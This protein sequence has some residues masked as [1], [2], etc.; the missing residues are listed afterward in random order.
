M[1]ATHFK[2]ALSTRRECLDI[3]WD[4]LEE[5]WKGAEE[6][7]MANVVM[8]R[9][10]AIKL[11]E[12]RSHMTRKIRAAG[13]PKFKVK[14]SKTGQM[15]TAISVEDVPTVVGFYKE[16]VHEIVDVEDVL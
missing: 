14:D 7:Y 3:D 10:L 11:G 2:N 16:A 13:I 8:V 1:G 12:D 5:S 9:D 6:A 15:V 4:A